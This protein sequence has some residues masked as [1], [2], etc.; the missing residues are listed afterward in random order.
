MA[1]RWVWMPIWSYLFC[2]SPF[3]PSVLKPHLY[4]YI[5]E[6][7]FFKINVLLHVLYLG[8]SCVKTFFRI[9]KCVPCMMFIIQNLGRFYTN[10]TKICPSTF[11]IFL[12]HEYKSQG[13]GRM[14]NIYK[15]RIKFFPLCPYYGNT[16]YV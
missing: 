16:Y 12:A 13:L 10:V 6:M 14:I 15:F 1:V 3:C 9:T 5:N 2:F 11:F 4:E 8:H 7:Q